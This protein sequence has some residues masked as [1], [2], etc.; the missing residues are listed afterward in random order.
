MSRLQLIV[1]IYLLSGI[2][3]YWFEWWCLSVL[4][5]DNYQKKLLY[6][7]LTNEQ[8]AYLKMTAFLFDLLTGPFALGYYI[9]KNYP[10]WMYIFYTNFYRPLYVKW[11]IFR[12]PLLYCHI[13]NHKIHTGW[14]KW[15]SVKSFLLHRHCGD[16]RSLHYKDGTLKSGKD[17]DEAI[18]KSDVTIIERD[19]SSV[20]YTRGN[21]NNE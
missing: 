6:D 15:Y 5:S 2:L 16:E 19:E 18:R 20:T 9:V 14:P 13:C 4:P 10:I 17:L 12:G 7:N 3:A 8:W 11:L 21:Y 1:S